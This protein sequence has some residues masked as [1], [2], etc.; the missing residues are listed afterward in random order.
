VHAYAKPRLQFDGHHITSVASLYNVF[1]GRATPPQPVRRSALSCCHRFSRLV[2]LIRSAPQVKNVPPIAQY[3]YLGNVDVV[4]HLDWTRGQVQP[5]IRES[6]IRVG[7]K[8]HR[9]RRASHKS[10]KYADISLVLT[11]LLLTSRSQRFGMIRPNWNGIRDWSMSC[12]VQRRMY[13]A[14][15]DM[16]LL[17]HLSGCAACE[18]LNMFLGRLDQPVL[19]LNITA[20]DWYNNYNSRVYGFLCSRNSKCTL[21]SKNLAKWLWPVAL[22]C[23]NVVGTIAMWVLTKGVSAIFNTCKL[24]SFHLYCST[25]VFAIASANFH[26]FQL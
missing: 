11:S 20:I 5:T 10:R 25:P 12:I 26:L 22:E 9:R 21:I 15:Y 17:T 14:F 16:S 8:R 23:V 7:Y 4:W 13:I 19:L 3:K 2:N 6:S 1:I 18:T 24:W